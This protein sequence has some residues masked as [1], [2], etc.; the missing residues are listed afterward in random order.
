ME[1]KELKNTSIHVPEVF[2]KA[3]H[4]RSNQDRVSY[5]EFQRILNGNKRLSPKERAKII[6]PSKIEE[7]Y[8]QNNNLENTSNLEYVS[9]MTGKP[10]NRNRDN[11]GI[12]NPERDY[13]KAIGG[14][15]YAGMSKGEFNQEVN[16]VFG[17]NDIPKKKKTLTSRLQNALNDPK[18]VDTAQK[19][20]YAANGLALIASTLLAVNSYDAAKNELVK[21]GVAGEL[22]SSLGFY[23][24]YKF[25]KACSHVSKPFLN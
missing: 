16:R 24:T 21:F 22:L 3:S 18:F 23:S 17:F 7:N 15:E 11:L 9:I 10:I 2:H 20:L 14:K 12:N 25:A 5:E 13:L 6:Y 19:V 8:T 1:N 4:Y